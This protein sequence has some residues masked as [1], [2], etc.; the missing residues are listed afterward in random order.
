MDDENYT[1]LKELSALPSGSLNALVSKQIQ[2]RRPPSLSESCAWTPENVERAAALQ[3]V[4]PVKEEPL[5][6]PTTVQPSAP[7]PNAKLVYAI[8]LILKLSFHITLISVFESLFFFFYISDLEDGGINKT[9]NGFVDDALHACSNFTAT[10][11]LIVNDILY[12]FINTTV[13]SSGAAFE[14]AARDENN[15]GYFRLSWYY[16][17][18][19]GGLFVVLAVVARLKKYAVEWRTL[20]LENLAMVTALGLYEYMFFTT[21]ISPYSP[22]S[23]LEVANNA[24]QKMHSTCGLFWDTRKN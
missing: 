6:F 13:I 7:L 2:L 23:G 1:E 19:F 24:I 9:I 10:E 16:V 18:G 5:I 20:F 17:G 3:L 15:A 11:R 8:N 12:A 22:I 21:V 4:S 14:V